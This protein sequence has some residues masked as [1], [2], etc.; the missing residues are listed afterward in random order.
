M[1]IKNWNAGIIRPVAVAPAGPYQNDA[2]PGVWTLDQ[3]AYWQKQGL[4]PTPGNLPPRGL[5]GGGT[6]GSAINVIQYITL[7]T[8]GNATDFGDLLVAREEIAACASTTRGIFAGA[9]NV[10]QYVTIATTS[11]STDFGDL[12]NTPDRLGG[13]S[14]SIRGLF[15]AGIRVAYELT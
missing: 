13:C 6:N 14:N 7:T 11:N 8:A 5:F 3:V 2:A 12:L 10:I 9:S 15:L 4:W 1:S